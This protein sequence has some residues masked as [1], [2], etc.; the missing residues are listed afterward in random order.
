[1]EGCTGDAIFQK[2]IA[3]CQDESL[4]PQKLAGSLK[5]QILENLDDEKLA[6]VLDLAVTYDEDGNAARPQRSA[7]DLLKALGDY[8]FNPEEVRS[9]AA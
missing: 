9:G 3:L 4:T 8:E 7:A 1:M 5:A 2:V 6:A